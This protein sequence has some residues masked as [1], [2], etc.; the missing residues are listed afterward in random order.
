MR[1][2]YIKNNK[3]EEFSSLI[4]SLDSA[5]TWN[6]VK[7]AFSESDANQ[8]GVIDES[9]W[10]L[11]IHSLAPKLSRDGH[12]VL[13]PTNDEV[14]RKF[15]YVFNQAITAHAGI[16]LNCLKVAINPIIEKHHEFYEQKR[17]L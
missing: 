1:Q 8:N 16:S 3:I 13:P 15:Y 10:V 11:F 9:E 17:N 2:W 5:E 7:E 6:A 14:I 4:N 12:T